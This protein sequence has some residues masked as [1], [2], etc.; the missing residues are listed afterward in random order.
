MCGRTH[1]HCVQAMVILC[2]A[3]Y[4]GFP[5]R[6]APQHNRWGLQN[7]YDTFVLLQMVKSNCVWSVHAY[8]FKEYAHRDISGIMERLGGV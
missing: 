1:V 8:R 6:Y 2:T 3:V 5:W 4:M 7:V